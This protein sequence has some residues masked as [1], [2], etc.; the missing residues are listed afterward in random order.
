MTATENITDEQCM[1]GGERAAARGGHYIEESVSV[2]LMRDL[3]GTNTWVID[4]A[5]LGAALET[6]NNMPSNAECQRRFSS[7]PVGHAAYRPASS[8]ALSPRKFSRSCQNPPAS[9]GDA[10][11]FGPR[12]E[13]RA[14]KS[15]AAGS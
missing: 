13:D 9:T 15:A 6:D 11:T 3:A 14:E 5:S 7:K 8:I 4:P 2:Y 1:T 12:R 10:S